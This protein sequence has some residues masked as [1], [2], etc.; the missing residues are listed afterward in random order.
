[1]TNNSNSKPIYN[2]EERTFQFAKNVR[3]FVKK[4]PTTI[5]NIEDSKHNNFNENISNSDAIFEVIDAY[6]REPKHRIGTVKYDSGKGHFVIEI[7]AMNGGGKKKRK[8][9]RKRSA[10]SKKRSRNTHS[11]RKSRS[12][13]K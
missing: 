3:L 4:L 7:H 10:L 12:I 9:R 5:S 1:M 11:K 2:L 8:T 6:Y 13:K